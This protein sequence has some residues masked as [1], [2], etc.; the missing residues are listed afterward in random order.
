M[1]EPVIDGHAYKHGIEEGDIRYA[2]KN[3]IRKQYRGAPNEGQI[4]A[5]GCDRGGNLIQMVAVEKPFGILIYHAM[6]PPTT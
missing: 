6:K 5:V 4:I 3:F 1:T 2:W